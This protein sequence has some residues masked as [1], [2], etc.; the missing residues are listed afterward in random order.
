M[1]SSHTMEYHSVT[2]KD[3]TLTPCHSISEPRQQWQIQ[4]DRKLT[5]GCQGPRGVIADGRGVSS[6]GDDHILEPERDEGCTALS[7]Y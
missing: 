1:W 4:R 2:E 5:S 7:M 3:E 6:W